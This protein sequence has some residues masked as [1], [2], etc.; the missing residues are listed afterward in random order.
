MCVPVCSSFFCNNVKLQHY[1]QD[2][3]FT[4]S[5]EEVN[6]DEKGDSIPSYD[7][8]NWQRGHEGNIEFINVGLF[9]GA[10]EAGKELLIQDTMIMW[11]DHRSKASCSQCVFKYMRC[12]LLKFFRVKWR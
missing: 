2:V 1:L 12:H 5:G 7:L 10:N 8:I 4:I 3:S 9:D 11:T 6:F